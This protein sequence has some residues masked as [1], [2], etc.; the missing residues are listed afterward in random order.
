MSPLTMVS[1]KPMSLPG[2]FAG[3]VFIIAAEVVLTTLTA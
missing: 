2:P 1:G 3:L